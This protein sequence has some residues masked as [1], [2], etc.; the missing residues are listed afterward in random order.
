MAKNDPDQETLAYN[1]LQGIPFVP[2]KSG[3]S[4][5]GLSRDASP[6]SA[7]D[8]PNR[9]PAHVSGQ[10]LARSGVGPRHRPGAHQIGR[11]IAAGCWRR[12]GAR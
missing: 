7:A 2:L 11:A 3:A 4:L 8:T 9:A 5:P 1:S 10:G 12:R 6:S